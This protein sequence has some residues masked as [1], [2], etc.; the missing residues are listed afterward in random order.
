MRRHLR[1][2]T[3]R[4]VRIGYGRICQET[5]AFS[6]VATTVDDFRRLHHRA[7]G[8]LARACGRLGQEVPGMIRNAELSGFCRAARRHG[9]GVVEPVPLVSSWAMPSGPLD[10]ATCVALRDELVRHLRHVGAV[11]GVFLTLHGAM[12]GRGDWAEPEERILAAVRAEVGDH[13]P[14]AITLDLHA[15]LTPGK[16]DPVDVVAGYRTNP[17]RDLARTGARA[18]DLLIGA[19]RGQIRPVS[20]WRSLPLV[21]GG[22][23]TIDFLR[24]MRP[25]FSRMKAMERDPRVLCVSLFMAHVW[26]DSPDLGWAVHVVTDDDPLVARRLADEL[27]D[28]AWEVRVHEPPRFL[29]PAEAIASVREARLARATGVVCVV[30]T[31]D[32]VGAG[33]AGENTNLLAALLEAGQGLT[34][35]VPMRDATAVDTLWSHRPGDEVD[36]AV[37]GRLDPER[38][39]VVEIRGRL[40]RLV[41]TR[42]FGRAAVVDLG[43]VHLVLTELAPFNVKPAFFKDLGL[44]PWRADAVVV[45]TL[46][47]YRVYYAAVARKHIPVRTRGSTDLYLF[48]S[49]DFREP[50]HP[51]VPVE[52]WRPADRRRRRG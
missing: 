35:Y 29:D 16:V 4:P 45:K 15:Q 11:D 46:F 7:A 51:L 27:A 44:D 22:G 37:G 5:N 25:I 24:P 19:A 9:R 21:L 13:V 20:A 30:D 40:R 52:D 26:N 1:P 23:L 12:R 17:H 6:P 36:L 8:D 2:V 38:N 43:H 3:S 39:P 32:V 18:G 41:R 33:A 34:W 49:N 14:I 47:H 28:R 31:S 42:Y 50:V 48:E 10:A